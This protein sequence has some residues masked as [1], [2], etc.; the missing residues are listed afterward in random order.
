V[1]DSIGMSFGAFGA[2]RSADGFGALSPAAMKFR[3]MIT[4]RGFTGHEHAD[5]LGIIHMNGRIYDPKLGR[6]L[7]ADPVV[8]APKNSQSLNRYTYVYNNPLSYTDPTGYFSL[9]RF[10]KKWGRLIVAVVVSYITYGA[11]SGWAAGWLAGTALAGNSI[12]IG[13]IAGAISG[14]VGGAIISGNLN[15][16]VKGAF[17]GAIM[18]GV[19][20]YF[21]NA[22]SLNRIAVDGVAGGISAEIYG[23]KFK[24]GLLFGALVSSVTYVSVRLRAYQKAKSKQFPGQI[25][26]SKGFRGVE[27]KLA[28]ERIFEKIWEESGAAA[29]YAEGKPLDWILKHKYIPYKG[30]LSPLGGLQGGK[31]LLFGQSYSPDGFIDYILESYSG[32]HDSFNQPFFYSSNGTNVAFTSQWRINIGYIINPINVVLATPIVIP[33]LIPDHL[34][35]LYF[36]ERYP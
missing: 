10:F 13:S 24:D 7:Q 1:A 20:G 19:A 4:T 15:G 11:A 6:F 9:K 28:G 36:Q 25:G 27:G 23:Q 5:G 34:R 14:F 18:G 8:Q 32:V 16:A 31:G 2:R 29:A 26:E 35:F 17:A 12:A 3:N 21:D 33:S 22:Y 30:K